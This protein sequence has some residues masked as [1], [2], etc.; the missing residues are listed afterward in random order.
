M[1]HG[2]SCTPTL[3]TEEGRRDWYSLAYTDEAT[4]ETHSTA[5][6]G[7]RSYCEVL[8]DDPATSHFVGRPNVFLSHAWLFNFRELVEDVVRYAQ[9]LTQSYDWGAARFETGDPD[10]LTP[11]QDSDEPLASC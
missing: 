2:C 9:R 1:P 6:C 8:A 11:V 5:P 4:G 10:E 7:T 3:V